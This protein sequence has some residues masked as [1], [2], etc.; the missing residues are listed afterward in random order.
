MYAVRP[1]TI[2]A[3]QPAGTKRRPFLRTDVPDHP[4]ERPADAAAAVEAGIRAM[5]T[6]PGD[7]RHDDVRRGRREVPAVEPSRVEDDGAAFR[8]GGQSLRFAL[9]GKCD[10]AL[11]G[12]E[13]GVQGAAL[14]SLHA[15]NER[16]LAARREAAIGRLD[17]DDVG[18]VI[19]EQLAAIA[20][21]DGSGHVEDFEA[22]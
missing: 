16:R 22:G 6:E 9:H 17:V 21:G 20:A 13:I 12:A 5:A 15:R 10:T 4:D 1:P 11:V 7:R 8:Q 3:P 14:G 19:R 2:S 18:T